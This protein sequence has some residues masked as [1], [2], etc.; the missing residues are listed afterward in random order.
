MIRVMDKILLNANYLGYT[1]Y[2]N[3]KSYIFEIKILGKTNYLI[4]NEY[5]GRCIAFHSISESNKVLIG[6]KK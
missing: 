1:I 2:N 4:A 5:S 3:R 6:I